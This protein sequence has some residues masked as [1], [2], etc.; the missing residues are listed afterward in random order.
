MPVRRRSEPVTLR[1]VE[2]RVETPRAWL[3]VMKTGEEV[4]MPKSQVQIDWDRGTVTLPRWLAEEK[5]LLTAPDNP[6]HEPG[7]PK[8][9]LQ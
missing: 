9:R 4:W 5:E 2:E 1:F 8:H 7:P 3:L 6:D